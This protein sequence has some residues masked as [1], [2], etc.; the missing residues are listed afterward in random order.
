MLFFLGAGSASLH[1]DEIA[2]LYALEADW[3]AVKGDTTASSHNVGGTV[4]HTVTIGPHTV[5]AVQMGAGNVETAI[6]ASRLLTK[7]PCD[8]AISI[9]PAGFIG[10]GQDHHRIFLV[11][12]VT[13]YQR[14]TWSPQGWSQASSANITL[15]LPSL[16]EEARNALWNAYPREKLAAG[17]VFV[18]NSRERERIHLETQ[19]NLIDMNSFG[20]ASVC[21][22]AHVPLLILKIC[23][24][25]AD[26]KAAEAFKAFV[27]AYD[28]ELG[29]MVR[30]WI[31]GLPISKD[32][33][34][35]YGEIQRALQGE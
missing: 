32:S 24:D 1:A 18:A 5:R 28:G 10:K 15:D 29:H 11:N 35:A 12:E 31:S 3:Q 34:K 23:S 19:A 16:G 17:D 8:R 33:P 14:G 27:S 25:S 26:D 4:V 21:Q 7:F 30:K 6:N 20:A 2:L 13:G 22:K 9:G